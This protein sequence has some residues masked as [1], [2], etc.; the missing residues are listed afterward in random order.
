MAGA[1]G[2]VLKKAHSQEI[3]D[4]IRKAD[5]GQPLIDPTIIADAQEHIR[6]R[7]ENAIIATLTDQEQKILELMIEGQTNR[8]IASVINLRNDVI[9]DHVSN[10]LGKLEISIR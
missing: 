9:R 10:I 5:I 1:S 2:Y 8:K 7:G 6:N 3:S 4:V